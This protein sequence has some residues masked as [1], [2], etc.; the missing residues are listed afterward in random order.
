MKRFLLLVPWVVVGILILA[1][2]TAGSATAGTAQGTGAHWAVGHVVNLHKAYEARLGHTKQSRI[3]GIVYPIGKGRKPF[4]RQADS[5]CT[6]PACLVTDQGG[7]IQLTP[8]VYLLLWGPNW[9]SDPNQ[10]ATATYLKKC[11]RGLG[12]QPRDNWSTVMSQYGNGSGG[13][14]TF[15]GVYMGA[16]QDLTTPPTGVSQGDLAAEAD[17]FATKQGIADLGDAQII[18]ATQSGTC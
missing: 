5:G 12:V 9:S 13:F 2:T 3:A 15:N 10:A 17:A 7:P 6:E 11:Y 16:F 14:P 8:H 1:L 18:V 4:Q